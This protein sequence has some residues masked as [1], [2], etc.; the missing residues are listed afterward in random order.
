MTSQVAADGLHVP[1]NVS[2]FQVA[3]NHAR[4]NPW[5]WGMAAFC[6]CFGLALIANM[7]AAADGVWFWY[8]VLHSAGSTLVC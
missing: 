4:K 7:Q 5:Q 2:L 1:E 6:F 8:A 3:M